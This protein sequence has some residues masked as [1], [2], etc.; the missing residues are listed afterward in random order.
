MMNATASSNPASFELI[1]PPHPETR[2]ANASAREI[3]RKAKLALIKVALAS[4]QS[5]PRR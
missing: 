5:K 3:R 2:L 1:W 4:G